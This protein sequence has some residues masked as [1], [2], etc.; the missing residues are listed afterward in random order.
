MALVGAREFHPFR[1]LQAGN[2][3]GLMVQIQ[4]RLE[5]FNVQDLSFLG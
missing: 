5:N 4:V 2:D 1:R 3:F